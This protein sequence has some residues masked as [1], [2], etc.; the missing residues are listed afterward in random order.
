MKI[1]WAEVEQRFATMTGEEFALI[2]TGDLAAPAK[3]IYDRE[4]QRRNPAEWA[5][6]QQATNADAVE[7]FPASQALGWGDTL[8]I[9]TIILLVALYLYAVWNDRPTGGLAQI[10]GIAAGSL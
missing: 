7:T 8:T 10:I 9:L 5:M 3:A 2:K 4:L 1:D 6:Q